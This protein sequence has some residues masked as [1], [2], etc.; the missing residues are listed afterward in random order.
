M[1]RTIVLGLVVSLVLITSPS[2]SNAG[3]V[4]NGDAYHVAYCQDDPDLAVQEGFAS[5]FP[6]AGS[7]SADMGGVASGTEVYSYTQSGKVTI[8]QSTSSGTV[9]GFASDPNQGR[10]G[11]GFFFTI[12]TAT[13]DATYS[14]SMTVN[15][16]GAADE[17]SASLLLFDY[18]T[19]TEEILIFGADSDKG[20]LAAGH[21]YGLFGTVYAKNYTRDQGGLGGTGS[22][23]ADINFEITSVP[24]PSSVAMLGL[25]IAGLAG[26][27]W[28]RRKIGATA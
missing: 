19:G 18:N 13:T 28:R 3:I 4:L 1:M 17:L 8:F 23:S 9:S 25:G 2:S 6:A 26:C 12:F 7:L 27:G 16:T 21:T 15:S 20:T 5:S 22:V 11:S 24:E 14:Y 10:Y